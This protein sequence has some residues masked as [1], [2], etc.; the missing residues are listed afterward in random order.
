MSIQPLAGLLNA[1]PDELIHEVADVFREMTD[2][3]GDR[4]SDDVAFAG[5]PVED[6][7][8]KQAAGRSEPY[9]SRK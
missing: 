5:S 8:P 1:S 3:S 7:V 2:L 9:L 6:W 4:E